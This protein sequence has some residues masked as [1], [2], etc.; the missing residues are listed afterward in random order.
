MT[1]MPLVGHRDERAHPRQIQVHRD[2]PRSTTYGCRTG[3][4][5]VGFPRHA[6][7]SCSVSNDGGIS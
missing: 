1:E 2:S 4:A 3:A 7:I 6:E 5:A